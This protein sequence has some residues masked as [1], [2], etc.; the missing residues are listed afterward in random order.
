LELLLCAQCSC[1]PVKMD[2]SGGTDMVEN[3]EKVVSARAGAGR[4]VP[5]ASYWSAC[6]AGG[7][8]AMVVGSVAPLSLME[9][10]VLPDIMYY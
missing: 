5:S 8:V 4:A 6:G 2:P 9:G 1:L 10:G 7:W 3:L